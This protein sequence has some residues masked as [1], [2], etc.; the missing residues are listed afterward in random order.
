MLSPGMDLSKSVLNLTRNSCQKWSQYSFQNRK[1]GFR[2]PQTF[3][4]ILHEMNRIALRGTEMLISVVIGN[5]ISKLQH[6]SISSWKAT[7]CMTGILIHIQ[8]D[9]LNI[10]TQNYIF[11]VENSS[12]HWDTQGSFVPFK[13]HWAQLKKKNYKHPIFPLLRAL[14]IGICNMYV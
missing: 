4:H 2:N 9:P 6:A 5:E 12:I 13:V 10:K 14:L 1:F 7:Y 11:L 3:Q 8:I